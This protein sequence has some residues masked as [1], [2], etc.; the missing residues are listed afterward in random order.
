MKLLSTI[1][2]AS[3]AVLFGVDGAVAGEG[4]GSDPGRSCFA[5]RVTPG[6]SDTGCCATVCSFDS[7][8]CDVEWD[9]ICRHNAV[10]L[11][12]PP[13]PA[14]DR[15][16]GAEPITT[17]LFEVCTIG[18]TD[19]AEDALPKGCGGMFGN[20]IRRD[21]WY[22]FVATHDGIARLSSCPSAASGVY[23]EFDPIVVVH[24]GSGERIA[25]NDERPDCGVYAEVEWD[26]RAG[27]SYL[28]QIGG[29][30]AY[31]GFG[32]YLLEQEGTVPPPACSADLSRDGV[33]G[34]QDITILLSAWG[35]AGGDVTGDGL[36]NAQDITAMLSAWG[37]CP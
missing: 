6:C 26:T 21:V 13:T 23:S 19:G 14:N 7:F 24:D 34:A 36:T 1:I 35:M 12:S 5:I 33:V 22:W 3:G 32:R 27:R 15:V 25:C 9:S 4:C 20:Q 16:A 18:A 29:H 37:A 28:V 31:V 17:G 2:L 10:Q 8:C 30:D 11:C